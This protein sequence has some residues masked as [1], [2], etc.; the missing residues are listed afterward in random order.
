MKII[1]WNV[2]G[3]KKSQLRQEVGFINRTINP[4]ILILLETL[5]NCQNSSLIISQLGYKFS[6]TIPP[7][8]HMGG[9]WL[10]WNDI[11]VDVSIIA[12]EPR[13]MHCLV[14]DKLT[15]KDCILSA[16]YAP[17]RENQKA[18]FWE[19]LRQL[20]HSIDKPWC[21][22]GDFNEMLTASDKF[23]GVPLTPNKTQRLNDFL[24]YSKSFDATVQGRLFT[25]KKFIKGKLVYEKLDRVIFRD[26]CLQLFP[27]YVV[28]NGPFTCSDHAYV[29]L[30]TDPHHAPRRG[31][32]FKY[33]HSWIHYQDIHGI[34]KRNWKNAISGTPIYRIVHKLKH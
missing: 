15:S 27:K 9:I 2:Q 12:K 17:A 31:T 3:A 14:H 1:C 20:H 21:I 29:F 16:V 34:I 8:N 25:W 26:D 28:T 5:V 32:T 24:H 18:V 23:G 11:N 33:Q 30:N 19:H 4:D 13:I 10:L 6:S 22:M 7:V